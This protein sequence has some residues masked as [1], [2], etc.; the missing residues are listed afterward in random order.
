MTSFPIRNRNTRR[1]DFL[2]AKCTNEKTTFYADLVLWCVSIFPL[3]F[4][5]YTKKLRAGLV[6]VLLLQ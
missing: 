2:C 1:I 4:Q 5:H 3:E 6:L